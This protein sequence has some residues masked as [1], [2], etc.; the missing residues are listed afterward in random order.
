MDLKLN[1]RLCRSMHDLAE[2]CVIAAR[3]VSAIELDYPP[4]GLLLVDG[5]LAKFRTEGV[6]S[7]ELGETLFCFGCYVG[8]SV[9]S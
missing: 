1:I 9:C 3:R 8:G 7:K 2:Q 5:Q 6:T 4:E